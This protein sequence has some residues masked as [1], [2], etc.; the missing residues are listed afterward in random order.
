MAR[1]ILLKHL[2]VLKK[3]FKLSRSIKWCGY[4]QIIRFKT[5][6]NDETS[7]QHT[8]CIAL[9]PEIDKILSSK[10]ADIKTHAFR[11]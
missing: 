8:K 5:K 1:K 11:K 3:Q 6:K 9:K 4:P 2:I 7:P 10:Y